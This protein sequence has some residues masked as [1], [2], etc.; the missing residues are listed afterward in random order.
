[1]H[2]Q[3]VSLLIHSLHS[4]LFAHS[5]FGWEFINWFSVM[6]ID[7]CA[8]SYFLIVITIARVCCKMSS[9]RSWS[10]LCELP[11]WLIIGY[12]LINTLGWFVSGNY[13][14]SWLPIELL[15]VTCSK[16]FT[17]FRLKKRMLAVLHFWVRY[18]QLSWQKLG[19]CLS[20]PLNVKGLVSCLLQDRVWCEVHRMVRLLAN[21]SNHF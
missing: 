3:S 2:R 17:L 16:V 15:W 12:P 10:S 8:Q 14:K 18:M 13:L 1:M 6:N 11:G 7:E 5:L 9:F 4:N 19:R 20:C 21:C